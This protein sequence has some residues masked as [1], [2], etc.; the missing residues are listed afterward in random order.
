MHTTTSNTTVVVC[1]TMPEP[2]RAACLLA[3]DRWC[4]WTERRPLE[5]LVHDLAT[6]QELRDM[7]GERSV[8]HERMSTEECCFW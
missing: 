4:R 6:G 8:F 5:L 2:A 1:Y 7:G 3:N